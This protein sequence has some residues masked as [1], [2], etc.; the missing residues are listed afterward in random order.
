MGWLFAPA[1]FVRDLPIAVKLAA[2][3]LGALSLLTGVSLFGV[4]RLGFIAGLQDNVAAQSAVEHRVQRALLAAQELR[5]VARELQMQQTPAAV[6]NAAERAEKQWKTATDFLQN[7]QAGQDRP[8]LDEAILRLNGLMDAV[9]HT[10]ALRTD[11]LTARQKR[12]FQVRPV[13]ETAL[14]TVMTE[15]ARGSALDGGVASVRDQGAQTKADDR[16]PAVEAANQYRLAMSRLQAATMMFMAAGTA[17]AS[18]DVWAA[19]AEAGEA[20]RTLTGLPLPD[21][22]KA[23]IATMETIG[24]SI[25]VAAA[26]LIA[27]TR[28]LD[29]LVGGEVENASQDMRAAF[30]ALAETAADRQRNAGNGAVSAAAD[31]S[32]SIWIMIGA[33][34]ATMLVLG[35]AV[36]WVLSVPI[37]RLTRIVQSIAA[38][39]TAENVP[40]T[41]WRDETGKMAGAVEKLRTVMRQTFIQ[42][43][44]IEQL[45]VGIMTAEPSG[46]V[47]ITYVNPEAKNVLERVPNLLP[48]PVDELVGKGIDVFHGNSD[49]QR[50]LIANPANLPHR[51]RITL[52][53]EALDLRISATHDRNGVYAGPLLIW[54]SA[55]AQT[56]LVKQFEQSVGAIARIVA[57]SAESMRH[58]AATMRESAVAAGSRTMA[59]SAASHQASQ[60]VTT[61]AAGAEQVAVSVAEIARQVAES[62]QIAATAVAE[63]EATD[64]SVSSLS[65]AAER[66][67]AVVRLISDIA[68]RTNLLALNATIEAARAGE[69]GKGFAVVASEVKNLASQTAK[70]TDEIGGQIAAMQ[71]A[72]AEAVT[73]LRSIGATIQR[74]NEIATIIAGSVEEQGAATQSIARAVQ[75]AA[76]G[77][78]EVTSNIASVTQVVDETGTQAGGVLDA[79][80][81]MTGQAATL[82]NEVARFLLAVQQAA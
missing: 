58:A 18:N 60:S 11:V 7:V 3:V 36:T 70:A 17:S 29:K 27:M 2:T 53:D 52:G 75:H 5:V 48:C 64:A 32:Q 65:D 71:S 74:M 51:A 57:E 55:T 21:G 49:R 15:I 31:A 9:R 1:R 79:A 44:M 66:I 30:E 73:A 62:A 61:A 39:E 54:R 45:P 67:S 8:L 6:R 26:D 72:T 50:Q 78:A 22:I 41:N 4:D 68:G 43:Q 40:Y 77:T 69:A 10:A 81:E 19:T 35:T 25:S 47:R 33:I 34:A 46:D 56:R 16:D 42:A 80:T 37:A 76:A 14:N 23:G 82:R 20:M 24:G 63:A 28:E 59:V 12:L 38:G 13:F